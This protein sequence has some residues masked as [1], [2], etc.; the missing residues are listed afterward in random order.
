VAG[1]L[2]EGAARAAAVATATLA[3]AFDAVGLLPPR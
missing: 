3:R 2:A 1:I